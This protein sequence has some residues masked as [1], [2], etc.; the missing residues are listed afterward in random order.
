VIGRRLFGG[1]FSLSILT[2]S[3]AVGVLLL[4]PCAVAEI[5]VSGPGTMRVSDGLLLLYLGIGG[6]AGTQLLWA[7]G[8]ADLDAAEVAIF[9]TLMPVV[10]VS[11]AAVLLG[12]A[13]TFV[14]ICG[15]LVVASGLFLTARLAAPVPSMRPRLATV[16]SPID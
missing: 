15:G 11:A 4:A 16:A 14:Q 10:G 7:R 1:G 13:I 8:M 6:S 12:E 9:G 2:G 5:A 3:I